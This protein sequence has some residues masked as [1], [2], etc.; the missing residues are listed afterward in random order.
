MTPHHDAVEPADVA[1][2]EADDETDRDAEHR[3]R[4]A[5]DQRHARAV[6]DAAVDVAAE[7][8]GAHPMHELA[9]AAVVGADRAFDAGHALRKSG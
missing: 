7:R 5:D 6:E 2:D 4:D 3:D 1:G 8:V 9:L